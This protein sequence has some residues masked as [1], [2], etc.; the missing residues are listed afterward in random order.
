M[1]RKQHAHTIRLPK[2]AK[3]KFIPALLVILVLAWV[4]SDPAGASAQVNQIK[5]NVVTFASQFGG[6]S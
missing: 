3:R 4:I 6:G 5:A 1:S 2:S